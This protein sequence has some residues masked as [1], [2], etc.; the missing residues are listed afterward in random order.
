[1]RPEDFNVASYANPEVDQLLEQGR[2]TCR[3]EDRAR[4]YRRVHEIL[5]DDVPVIFLYHR[6]SLPVVT[7]RIRGVVPSPAGIMYNFNEWFVP[8]ELQRYTSG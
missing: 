6:E 1:M 3:V 4:A 5:A 8:R 2:A 7:S